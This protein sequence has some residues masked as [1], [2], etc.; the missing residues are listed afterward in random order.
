MDK[1]QFT[2]I[3]VSEQMNHLALIGAREAMRQFSIRRIKMLAM[4]NPPY[5]NYHILNFIEDKTVHDILDK[6]ENSIAQLFLEYVYLTNRI[7]NSL[8]D[9]LLDQELIFK[10]WTPEWW[11]RL[12]EFLRVLIDAERKR[13]GIRNLYPGFDLMIKY[14]YEVIEAKKQPS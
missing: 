3:Y 9:G 1:K 8:E 2:L 10:N 12:S 5:P 4:T 14:A 7:G 13:R 11:V 6:D